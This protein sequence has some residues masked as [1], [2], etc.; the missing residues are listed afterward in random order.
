MSYPLLRRLPLSTLDRQVARASMQ[1]CHKIVMQQLYISRANVS[2]QWVVVSNPSEACINL[3]G[4]NLSCSGCDDVYCFPFNYTLLPGDEVT[5]WCSP[6]RLKLDEDNLLQPYLFWTQPDGSLRHKSFFTSSRANDVV[7]LDPFL[8]EVASIRVTVDGRREFRVLHCKSAHSKT[9][10]SEIDTRFCV[11]CLSP[12]VFDKQTSR[13]SPESGKITSFPPRQREVYVYSRYWGIVSDKS[14]S[15]HSLAVILVP[16]VESVRAVLIYLMFN[17]FQ[18]MGKPGPNVRS[19]VTS[20]LF[21]VLACNVTA[22][23]LMLGIKS[24][25]LVTIASFTS[26]VLDQVAMLVLYL[27]LQRLYP[28]LTTSFQCMLVFDLGVYCINAIAVQFRFLDERTNWHPLFK[29]LTRLDHRYQGFVCMCGIGRELLLHLLFLLPFS[30][31]P[32]QLWKVVGYLLVPFFTA[33]SG[34]DFFRA[35]VI[36]LHMVRRSIDLINALWGHL[37]QHTTTYV[38]ETYKDQEEKEVCD[39]EPQ[40]ELPPSAF[41]TPKK[42][43]NRFRYY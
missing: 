35:L 13:P 4:F 22:R 28:V 33:A 17:L 43:R 5:I 8:V 32:T 3:T 38:K 24:G 14:L 18:S 36:L 21:M 30:S 31:Q 40:K 20:L 19:K 39:E 37:E 12:P 6:G 23:K 15:K 34:I 29:Y 10:R 11:G 42:F 9:L 16:V 26:V 27:S 7:L 1:I 41:S 25:L 2:K